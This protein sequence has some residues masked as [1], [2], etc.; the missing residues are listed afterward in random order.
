MVSV[1]NNFSEEQEQSIPSLSFRWNVSQIEA[2]A[3]YEFLNCNFNHAFLLVLQRVLRRASRSNPSNISFTP[4][5]ISDKEPFRRYPSKL[6]ALSPQLHKNSE[7]EPFIK[8]HAC[9]AQSG[10]KAF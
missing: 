9:A 8:L 6:D 3:N 1:S 5:L 4:T 10:F 7:H 2:Y